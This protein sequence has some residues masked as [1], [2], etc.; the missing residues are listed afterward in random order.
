M[1]TQS[2]VLARL[3]QLFPAKKI[4]DRWQLK[5]KKEEVAYEIAKNGA[6]DVK[7]FAKD[8]AGLTRQIIYV[9]KHAKSPL[10]KIPSPVLSAE[11]VSE[12]ADA[13]RVEHFYLTDLVYNVVLQ[14][15]LEKMDLK[16]KWPV[17]VVFEKG[18][19]RVHITM[20]EKNIAS[21]FPLDRL[22]LVGKKNLSE[23]DI[24]AEICK[25]M[26]VDPLNSGVDLN[27][28][29]KTL[30]ANDLF[31]SLTARWKEPKDTTT[32]AMDKDCLLKRDNYA[33][34]KEII[35]APLLKTAFK[36]LKESDQFP[37]HFAADPTFGEISIPTFSEDV[38]IAENVIREIL[39]YN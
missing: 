26:G 10:S 1:N 22:P 4:K 7:E 17:R 13:N 2:E 24:M 19:F 27:K 9:R 15:P 31:D 33:A 35:K 32:K 25:G 39:K 28:G 29:I 5:G 11:L 38:S 6:D 16:F 36:F 3:L 37:T 23:M 30:W 18:Y 20:M 14:D 12:E 34:Y 21:Y 8:N